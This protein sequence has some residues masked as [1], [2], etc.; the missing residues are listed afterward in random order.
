MNRLSHLFKKTHKKFRTL[1]EKVK[2]LKE[3]SH[4]KKDETKAKT[5]E[6]AVPVTVNISS[7]SVAKAAAVIALF[8]ALA[9]IVYE[10]R[11]IILIFFV[12]FILSAALDPTVDK[13]EAKRIPRALSI[14]LIYLIFFIVL[15]VF[16]SNFIPLIAEQVIEL[17]GRIG[18]IFTNLTTNGKSD[19][20]FMDKIKPLIGQFLESADQQTL[21]EGIQTSLSEFGEQL[22]NIAGNAWKAL[23]LVFRSIFNVILTLVLTFFMTMEERGIQKFIQSLFPKKYS[24]Y[25]IEK[26]EAVKEKIGGWIRGQLMLSLAVGTTIFIGLSIIN[27]FSPVDIKYTA[28]L[29]MIAA[30]T[31]FIPY[32]GPILASIPAILI[33]LNLSPFL[34]LWVIFVYWLTNWLENNFL[35]PVIMKKA[36]GLSPVITIFAMLAGFHFLKIVGII[37]AVPVTTIIWIFL[38]DY[39]E[40]KK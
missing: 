37:L 24:R 10:I 7:I 19:I 28:T 34:V 17:A 33:A 40:K 2:F 26:S 18:E 22:K 38:R 16:I 8:V 20:P 13:L 15:G 32:I 5:P 23:T 11:S 30:I 39:S 36:V 3:K 1:Q 31:E 29:A 25:I 4:H 35:V 27:I 9:F 6:K 12:A 14:L 21:V